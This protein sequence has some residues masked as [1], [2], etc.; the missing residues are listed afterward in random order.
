ML[1]EL[2][3]G[4]ITLL[5]LAAAGGCYAMSFEKGA[6]VALGLGVLFELAFWAHT[7]GRK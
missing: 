3:H 6:G 7:F 2:R 5:L 1:P 4:V